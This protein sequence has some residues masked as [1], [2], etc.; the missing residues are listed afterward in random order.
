MAMLSVVDKLGYTEVTE[1]IVYDHMTTD[2]VGMLNVIGTKA[3]ASILKDNHYTTEEVMKLFT[4]EDF[5]IE[6]VM[7]RVANVLNMAQEINQAQ[8]DEED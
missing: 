4:T 2:R 8:V 7:V 6:N 5:K 1:N 3:L